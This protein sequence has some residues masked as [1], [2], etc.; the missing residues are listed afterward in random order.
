MRRKMTKS[1]EYLRLAKQESRQETALINE[2]EEG[3]KEFK[4][5]NAVLIQ[6]SAD[7]KK[8]LA[9]YRRTGELVLWDLATGK[10]LVRYK[11]NSGKI[12][13]SKLTKDGK[14]VLAFCTDSTTV[15]W[16]A[17]NGSLIKVNREKNAKSG[18]I[19][20]PDGAT[21]LSVDMWRSVGLI[22]FSNQY[23]ASVLSE[24]IRVQQ[25]ETNKVVTLSRT[26]H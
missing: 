7:E 14:Y 15:L 3:I 13:N 2:V 5:S 20:S 16:N 10:R 8:L 24:D 4:T 26:V 21:I 22:F 25:T 12:Y 9:T 23:V 1:E 6:F 17:A 19:K 18:H 11:G